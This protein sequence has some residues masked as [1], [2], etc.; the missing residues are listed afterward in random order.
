MT[1]SLVEANHIERQVAEF[2]AERL[3]VENAKH[4][5]FAVDRGHDRNAKIDEAA[6]VAN[7]EAAVLG[8]AALRDIELAHHLDARKDGGVP[9]LRERLH[10]VLQDAVD[11]VLHDHF[12]VA[13]FDV[14][15]ARAALEGRENH[16]I[17][18]AND[19]AHARVARVSFSIEMFS[20]LSSSSLTT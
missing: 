19:G 8:D 11:A 18:E 12:G 9:I 4:G 13:R 7:A 10:G 20:S 15:V 14:N 3:L 6:L 17:H 1:S 5:V 2:L 16:R